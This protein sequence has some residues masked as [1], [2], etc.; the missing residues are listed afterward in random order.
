VG[1][2]KSCIFDKAKKLCVYLA[3]NG[4]RPPTSKPTRKPTPLPTPRHKQL[5]IYST[6]EREKRSF[7]IIDYV[8]TST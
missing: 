7:I 8:A 3:S 4:T 2:A 1:K 5:L 6:R